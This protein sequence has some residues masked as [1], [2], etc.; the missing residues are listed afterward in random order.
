L[1]SAI[2]IIPARYGSKRFPGKPLAPI[3]GK[4]LIQRVYER[5]LQAESLSRVVI[6][7]DDER[8]FKASKAFGASVEMTSPLHVSG[9]ARVAEVARR[10]EADIVVNIQGDEPLIMGEMVD[11]LVHALDDDSV[12]MATL[13]IKEYDRRCAQDPNIVKVTRDSRGNALYF[14]RSP[15]P[16]GTHECFLR[17]IG[18]Y[19]YQKDFLLCYESLGRGELEKAENL[20][21]LRAL[22]NGYRIK[23]IETRCSTLSVDTPDDILKVE[24]LLKKGSND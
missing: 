11:S 20:E 23:L 21:Q 8:I 2:G 14:S 6:A 19:G 15:I 16:Y 4:P 12:P 22:E 18:L 17:H 3:L 7:T 5:S 13:Y 1:K 10:S 9:T 24:N